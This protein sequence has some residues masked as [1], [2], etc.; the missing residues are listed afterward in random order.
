MRKDYQNQE[1]DTSQPAVPDTVSVTLTELASEMREGLLAL[2]VGAGL[3]VM[4][5]IMEED[6][7]AACEPKGR[8][9]SERTATRHGHSAG[10]VTLGGRRVP[11]ERPRMRA[12]DGSGELP[13]PAY[14]LFS[15]EVLGRMALDLWGSRSQ[16]EL[17]T[18]GDRLPARHDRD[19]SLRLLYLIFSRL[20]TG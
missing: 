9:D 19:V 11:V 8:H 7:T 18:C 15:D 16:P 13:V 12:V 1:I 10:S 2:A 4:A 14:E 5:A 6:V 3:Q 20:L 17:V